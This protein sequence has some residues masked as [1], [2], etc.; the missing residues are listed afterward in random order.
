MKVVRTFAL[1]ELVWAIAIFLL[2]LPVTVLT[3]DS[4]SATVYMRWLGRALMLAAFPAGIAIAGDV[5]ATPR[6]WRSLCAAVTAASIAAALVLAVFAVAVP[7]LGEERTLPQLALAMRATNG[8][9]GSRNDA[10]WDFFSTLLTPITALLHAAIGLQ[11]GLWATHA[12]PPV[13]RRLLYWA[14]GL[15]LMI[16]GYAVFDSTYETIVLHTAAYV[17]FAA[18]YTLLIPAGICAGLGLPTLALLR[19][20]EIHGSAR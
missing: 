1:A 19:G 6:P 8:S 18:F 3:A 15:G 4:L 13:L 10:A 14:I 5:F 11:V 17:D 20:A 2:I 12:V 16:T 9:W 7:L